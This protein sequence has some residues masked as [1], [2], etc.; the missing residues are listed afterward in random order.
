MCEDRPR[1]KRRDF[2]ILSCLSP[3]LHC[4]LFFSSSYLSVASSLHPFLL[5]LVIFT[6]HGVGGNFLGMNSTY[7]LRTEGAKQ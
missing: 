2:P 1:G 7:L 6:A 3:G 4:S 5:S